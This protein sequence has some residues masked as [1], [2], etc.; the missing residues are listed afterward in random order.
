MTRFSWHRSQTSR[1]KSTLKD[2]STHSTRKITPASAS[3]RKVPL[4]LKSAAGGAAS[5]A[6]G[7]G[8]ADRFFFFF[9]FA[10]TFSPWNT[11]V[12]SEQRVHVRPGPVWSK[13]PCF[14]ER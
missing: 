12:R 1:R 4:A 5:G 8:A 13:Y 2:S 14:W 9:F 6:A 3:H 11:D 7:L 10:M